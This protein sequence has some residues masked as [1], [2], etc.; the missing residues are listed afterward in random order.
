MEMFYRTNN[1]ASAV[2][3]ADIP[4]VEYEA[5][6]ND[7]KERMADSRYHVAHYFATEVES[8]L[9]FYMILL[10]DKTGDVLVT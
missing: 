9:R 7:L 3:I 6:Y 5:L 2:A 4:V 1:T 10:D 8:G